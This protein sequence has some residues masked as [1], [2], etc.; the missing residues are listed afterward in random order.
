MIIIAIIRR[1][2]KTA[3]IENGKGPGPIITIRGI[4]IAVD[5]HPLGNNHP[6]ANNHLKEKMVRKRIKFQTTKK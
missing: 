1:G 2:M 5:A 6:L 4:M 3:G